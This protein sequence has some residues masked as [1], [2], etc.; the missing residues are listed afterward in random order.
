MLM[1]GNA[2]IHGMLVALGSATLKGTRAVAY[3]VNVINNLN[4]PNPLSVQV[5]PG[6]WRELSTAQP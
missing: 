6:T 3:N 1:R 4:S 2:E 5:V